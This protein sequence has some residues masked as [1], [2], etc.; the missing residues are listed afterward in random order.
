VIQ[1]LTKEVVEAIWGQTRGRAQEA[2]V[3]DAL[4]SFLEEQDYLVFENREEAIEWAMA[5]TNLK[6]PEE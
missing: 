1:N 2:E 5:N 6:E 4:Q 3:R